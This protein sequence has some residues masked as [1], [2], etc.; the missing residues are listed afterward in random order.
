MDFYRPDAKSIALKH[1]HHLVLNGCLLC[2]S[3]L[4]DPNS[5]SIKAFHK[6]KERE[7]EK[8]QSKRLL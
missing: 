8:K 4:D 3:R 6:L 7:R 1:H 5:N 2:E